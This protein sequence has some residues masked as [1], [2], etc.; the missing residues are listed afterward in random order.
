LR[1]GSAFPYAGATRI[2]VERI[3]EQPI[4]KADWCADT[5]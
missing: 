3:S 4:V 1:T 2:G 5:A